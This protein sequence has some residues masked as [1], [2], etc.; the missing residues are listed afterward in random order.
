MNIKPCVASIG[1]FDGVHRG[2]RYLI[3]QVKQEA[4][5]KGV[6]SALIT[7]PVHP[8]LVMDQSYKPEL[9]TSHKEKLNLLSQTGLDYCIVLDFTPEM[10]R[11]SAKAFMETILKQYNVCGLV[12]GHD[13][14]FGHNRS[15]GFD[16][17]CRF[18]KELGIDV[19][20]ARA[21]VIDDTTIS[22][23]VIRRL[24]QQGEVSQANSYLGYNYFL[25][26][27]VTGGHQVGRTLG[28]PTA[29]LKIDSYKLIPADGVYAVRVSVAGKEYTGML[30]IGRRPTI[31]NGTDRTIEV[32]ILHFHSDIYDFPVKLSFVEFIRPEMKFSGKEELRAQLQKDAIRVEEVCKKF[33]D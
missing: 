31:D 6:A 5:K 3:E 9:L 23:S 12:I 33:N 8:R 24:L 15:E 19:I 30:N 11:L 14:R 25:E 20:R 1:F 27:I 22:S 16:D 2:H 26:G 10:S 4:A 17:Y 13:H 18:G 7:F 29:N 21:Y 28:F 32:H